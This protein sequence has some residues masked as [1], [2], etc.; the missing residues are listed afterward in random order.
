MC[1]ASKLGTVM[2][3]G[4]IQ[5]KSIPFNMIIRGVSKGEPIPTNVEGKAVTATYQPII[6]PLSTY[7]YRNIY[8]SPNLSDGTHNVIFKVLAGGL[9][10]GGQMYKFDNIVTRYVKIKGTMYDDNHVSVR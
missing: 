5:S 2:V 7:G 8:T 10:F 1:D 3:G 9:K 6:S 4:N